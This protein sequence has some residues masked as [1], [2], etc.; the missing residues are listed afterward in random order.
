MKRTIF[1][2]VFSIAHVLLFG[3]SVS[4]DSLLQKADSIRYACNKL[5]DKDKVK[6]Y[7]QVLELQDSVYNLMADSVRLYSAFEKDARAFHFF[8]C[9]DASVFNQ[10]YVEIDT[11][12]LPKYLKDHYLT[13]STIRLYSLCIGNIESKIKDAEADKD[14]AEAD[15]KN[16]VAIKIKSEIDNANELLDRIDK[17]NMYSF[18]EEQNKFYHDLSERLTNIL[19]KYIF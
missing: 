6:E 17:L 8:A 11:L 5:R 1:I 10:D 4:V 19:N 16:F 9:T 7:E 13:V 15:K 18:S 2:I 12:K 14:V 3:Q